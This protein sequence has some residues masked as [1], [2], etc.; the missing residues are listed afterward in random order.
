MSSS[1]TF[2]IQIRR[3]RDFQF[4]REKISTKSKTK[5]KKSNIKE[6]QS[7]NIANTC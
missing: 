3:V 1:S 4:L 2:P 5:I 7:R 6:Y